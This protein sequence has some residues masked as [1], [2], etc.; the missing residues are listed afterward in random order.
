MKVKNPPESLLSENEAEAIKKL[1]SL[2]NSWGMK[3][4]YVLV[5]YYALR[6]LGYDVEKWDERPHIDV[7]INKNKLGWHPGEV[8][9]VIPPKNS[10][11]FGPWADYIDYL[12]SVDLS[13]HMIP[14]PS[15]EL[16]GLGESLTLPDSQVIK[17]S[18]PY[19]NIVGF[20]KDIERYK[21]LA[22]GN[23]EQVEIERW[24]KKV[25]NIRIALQKMSDEKTIKACE[26]CDRLLDE[27][28]KLQENK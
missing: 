16:K 9:E 26:D 4:D 5:N 27:L 19:Q 15:G 1:A 24:K 13:L 6:L 20:M 23:F 7:V 8:R 25:M 18:T 12:S 14:I 2:M 21:E 22:P 11:Y 28:S 10:S 3:N 17:A